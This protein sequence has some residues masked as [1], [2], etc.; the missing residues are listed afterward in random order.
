MKW[1]FVWILLLSIIAYYLFECIGLLRLIVG[2]FVAA[3]INSCASRLK[4]RSPVSLAPVLFFLSG[5]L[6]LLC[7]SS[8]SF[9]VEKSVSISA[10][11]EWSNYSVYGNH[12]PVE[13][14][15]RL[16]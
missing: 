6:L 4:F 1:P 2:L 3:I 14:E 5:V 13:I 16:R 10:L 12:V 7:A 8:A 9:R 11:V 15:A